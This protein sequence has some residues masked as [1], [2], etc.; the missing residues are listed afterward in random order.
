MSHSLNKTH[1]LTPNPANNM[2]TRNAVALALAAVVTVGLTA[3]GKSEKQMTTEERL[4]AVSM[5][6]SRTE[7]N[8]QRAVGK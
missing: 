4:K 2:R 8:L 6:A 5:Q 7:R 3:C 1:P